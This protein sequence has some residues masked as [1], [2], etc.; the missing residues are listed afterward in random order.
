M[1]V[2]MSVPGVVKIISNQGDI[3]LHGLIMEMVIL[4]DALKIVR[5]YAWRYKAVRLG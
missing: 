2:A 4:G 5:E 1:C 3:R